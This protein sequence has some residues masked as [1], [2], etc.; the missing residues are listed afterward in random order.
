LN[1]HDGRLTTT[2][3][4]PPTLE[5]RLWLR[6][7]R[8]FFDLGNHPFSDD[9]RAEISTRNFKGETRVVRDVLLRCLQLIGSRP[10]NEKL[11]RNEDE[12]LDAA[13]HVAPTARNDAAHELDAPEGT[14]SAL[15]EVLQDASRLGGA[16]LEAPSVGFDGWS[17]LCGFLSRELARSEAAQLLLATP[18]ADAASDVQ[19]RLARLAAGLTPDE[20]GADTHAVFNAFAG[21][22]ERLRFAESWLKGGGPIKALLAVFTLVH[23]ETRELLDFVEGRA[24]RVEGMDRHFHETLDGTAY[25]VRMEL[26]K[27][28]EHELVGVCALRQPPQVYAKL[29]S[30]HGLLRDCYQQSVVALGQCL[31]PT[32][33]GEEL[34]ASFQT[35]LEQSLQLRRD[36]WRLVRLARDAAANPEAYP[37]SFVLTPLHEFMEG[38]MRFLMFKDWEPFERLV[39]EIE[40]EQNAAGLSQ[41]IHRFE[42]FL[43]TL[44]GQVNM[45]AVLAWHPF[46]PDAE[47]DPSLHSREQS[48]S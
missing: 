43:E 41:A 9:E 31:D 20:L 11:T 37:S 17:G 40:E 44:F 27:T 7:L 3:S 47:E 36:L 34:F 35:K 5:L 6:A 15:A 28:F 1:E 14:L 18:P 26:R 32:L 39:E 2:P 38:S 8:S 46:T 25:A 19:E 42:A 29:E 33:K 22:L 4:V 48:A 23:E 21:L 10:A 30:S 24:L 12:L 16:L 45:R 13:L